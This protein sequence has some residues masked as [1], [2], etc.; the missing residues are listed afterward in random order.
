M[1]L[2]T[3]PKLDELFGVED[4]RPSTIIYL[5]KQHRQRR[6]SEVL[7]ASCRCMDAVTDQSSRDWSQRK[8]ARWCRVWLSHHGDNCYLSFQLRITPKQSTRLN[9]DLSFRDI[10]LNTITKRSSSEI[11]L[12]DCLG[13]DYLT[14]S[15]PPHRRNAWKYSSGVIPDPTNFT[16]TLDRSYRIS[17]QSHRRQQPMRNGP[18]TTIDSTR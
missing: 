18:N 10:S 7:L 14:S 12:F 6:I 17:V 11:H 3:V 16:A 13:A 2:I 1:L 5:S 9:G 8:G 4:V 15:I